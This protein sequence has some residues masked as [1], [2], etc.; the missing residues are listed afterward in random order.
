MSGSFI[1][2]RRRISSTLRL[3]ALSFPCDDHIEI[4][5]CAEKIVDLRGRY[6]LQIFDAVFLFYIEQGFF[7][8]EFVTIIVIDLVC[9]P[10]FG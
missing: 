10:H 9:L 4:L 7:Q 2:W 6:C 3:S 1:S 8:S 5:F